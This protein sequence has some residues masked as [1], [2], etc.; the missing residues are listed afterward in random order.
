M[1][2]QFQRFRS[3]RFCFLSSAAHFSCRNLNLHLS[4]WSSGFARFERSLAVERLELLELVFPYGL[5]EA[6]RL[7]GLNDWNFF[8][9]DVLNGAPVLS[10]VEG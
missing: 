4:E 10:N 5:N 1:S 7:N 3:R 2:L 8:T 9:L 6:Q